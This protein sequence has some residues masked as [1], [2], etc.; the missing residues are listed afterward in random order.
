MTAEE[1]DALLTIVRQYAKLVLA[2][3]A[4]YADDYGVASLIAVEVLRVS[5][6]EKEAMKI[7]DD[8]GNQ[9]KKKLMVTI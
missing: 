5:Y 2:E 1:K 9:V 8:I 4:T 3:P 6:G 7:V